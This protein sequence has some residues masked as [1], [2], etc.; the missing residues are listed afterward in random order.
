MGTNSFIEETAQFHK[1]KF[2]EG[3]VD[4]IL[5]CADPLA[6]VQAFSGF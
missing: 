2:K 4:F 6:F 1:V 5:S 3:L